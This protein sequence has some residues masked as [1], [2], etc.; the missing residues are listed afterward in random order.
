V[1]QASHQTPVVERIGPGR[2]VLVVGPSGAGKD[3]LMQLA[4]A[5]LGDRVMFPAR[6]VTRASS[7]AEA[8]ESLSRTE[9]E[10]QFAAGA[11]AFHWDAHGLSYGIRRGIDDELRKGVAVVVNVSRAVVQQLRTRYHNVVVVLVTAPADV[12]AARLAQRARASDGALQQR[13][14]RS[15]AES[16]FLP[17]VTIVNV[18]NASERAQDLVRAITR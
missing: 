6:V 16:E 3:T 11:F 9:F 17:D 13:L 7:E 15:V 2:L 18:G 5:H 4:R 8:H 12:L 14:A 10:A 1:R